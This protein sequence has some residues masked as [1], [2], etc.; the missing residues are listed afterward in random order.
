M[1]TD[2]PDESELVQAWDQ[3]AE[4]W[5]ERV[6]TGT[7]H[8]REHLLDP[9]TL[10]ALGDVAGQR[11]LDAGCGEGRFGRMLAE[12]G[13]Q[14]TGVDYSP[15][16]IELAQEEERNRPLGI[17]YHV[18]DMVD[19]AFLPAESFDLA[20]AYMCLMDVADHQTA[21][22]Q[23]ARVLKPAGR[24]VFSLMHPCFVTP[25]EHQG[26]E[27]RVPNSLRDADR[28]YW[29]VDNYFERTHWF[30]KIWPT[31]TAATPHFHRPLCDYAAALRESGLL[32]RDLVE[33][34]PDPKLAEQ[35]DYW[36]GYFRIPF[37]TIFDCVKAP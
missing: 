21:I 18:A 10:A 7:D 36:R 9:A 29:K 25:G 22:A 24:F 34:T 8:N 3:T 27:L 37:F 2:R 6:R 31:A 23:I 32:I 11:V 35:L 13:A 4:G 28:L 16:M 30:W 5:A 33:P 12:R 26:W 1:T 14:V 20:V 17:R 15:R 19:L